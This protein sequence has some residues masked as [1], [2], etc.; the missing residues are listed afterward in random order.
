MFWN[1]EQRTN[2][3]SLLSQSRNYTGIKHYC[4]TSESRNLSD[5]RITGPAYSRYAVAGRLEPAQVRSFEEFY[6]KISLNLKCK[7]FWLI[8]KLSFKYRE[9]HGA[10]RNIFARKSYS[11]ARK[12]I[13][14]ARKSIF[15]VQK[16]I[17][18]V[19]FPRAYIFYVC[20]QTSLSARKHTYPRANIL[21]FARG[22]AILRAEK[23]FC[24][25]TSISAR[26]KVFLGGSVSE[27]GKVFLARG[28]VFLARDRALESLI[29][30]SRDR[31][32][33]SL[34]EYLDSDIDTDET[35]RPCR[36][37]PAAAAAAAAVPLDPGDIV[38][39]HGAV[40]HDVPRVPSEEYLK[41]EK[42]LYR[43]HLLGKSMAEIDSLQFATKISRIYGYSIANILAEHCMPD[44]PKKLCHA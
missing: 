21:I 19:T 12:S 36:L 41:E 5:L 13:F 33:Q 39:F 10:R 22:K 34:I 30:Y 20:A 4:L 1:K 2:L 6:L 42:G 23:S 31:A 29:E 7:I 27:R 40:I 18:C 8:V 32:L 38:I 17:S 3:R 11:S 37:T 9:K 43:V 15:S 24:A 28:K 14:C 44:F 35:H 25:R 26:G 16:S